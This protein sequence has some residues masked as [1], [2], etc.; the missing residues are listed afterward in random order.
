MSPI[1]EWHEGDAGTDNHFTTFGLIWASW[2]GYTSLKSNRH[3][4]AAASTDI[5]PSREVDLEEAHSLRKGWDGLVPQ[6]GRVIA[7]YFHT[8][9]IKVPVL[10]ENI[11]SHE[12]VVWVSNDQRICLDM[13]LSGHVTL[14]MA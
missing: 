4:C 9:N 7:T 1:P 3:S 6:L 13:A 8:P 14:H 11:D 12:G 10:Q 5:S 2:R